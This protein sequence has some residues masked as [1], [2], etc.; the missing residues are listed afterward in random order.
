MIGLRKSWVRWIAVAAVTAACG[1][2]A[3]AADGGGP[4]GRK[5][6]RYAFPIAETAFDPAQVTDIYSNAVLSGIFEAPLEYTFLAAPVGMRPNT[7]A[8]MPEVSADFR[9]FTFRIRPGIYFA[10]D[11][12][13][14]GRKR[15]LVAEDYVYS[16]KRH[17]DPR[18]KSGKLSFFENEKI[19]G[20]SELRKKAIDAKKPFDYDT[21]AEGLRA[22]DRYTFQ[23]KLAEPS[24]RF[25]Y[26]Y[27]FGS[28][29][30]ALAR[31]VVEA[32]GDLIGEHPVG[33]GPFMLKEWKRSSRIV[34]VRNPNYRDVRYDESP[35][36]GSEHLAR[37]AGQLKGRR[38]PMVDEVHISII[39]ESQPR[40]LSFLNAEQ[41]LIEAV[42]SDFATVAFPNDR[43]APHLAKRGIT[44]ARYARADAAFSYF[45]MENPVVG[46]YE[47]HKVALRRAISLAV[48]VDR[49]IRLVRQ[50]QAV[51]AQGPM[52]PGTFG[53]DH[54]FKT[55]LSEFSP[56]RA[57]ALL[58][59]HGYVDRD[60]D[61]WREQPDGSPLVLRY[62]T[63]PDQLSRQYDELWQK[64]MRAIGLRIEF[65]VAKFPEHL[66]ASRAGR[67]MM[68]G[69]AW[70]GGEP[71]ADVFLSLAYGPNKGGVNH[72]R[73]DL[74]A[75]NALYEKQ[76]RLPDGPE[77][78]AVMKDAARLMVAYMPLKLQV[79][80]VATDL[81]HPWLVGYNRHTFNGLFWKYVDIDLAEQRRR[82]GGAAL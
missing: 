24:P 46:G 42:P 56:A 18:W 68:F 39:E 15:Q 9:T 74:P 2:A 78:L 61:G 52:P 53:H 43:L 80:R 38:L 4:Q 35:P 8:G 25:L 37:I 65:D 70:N 1:A 34:L 81:A 73:F 40:W 45:Q 44:M 50:G 82:G 47:P 72:S 31:E 14:K 27:V 54:Q 63:T 69:M 55:T 51:P 5:V 22:L 75:Y 10:D 3:A 79:H 71:D 28:Y 49:Q 20:L 77:R 41:D 76:R 48:D 13:F 66:K 29:A 19:L 30:G 6:L 64:N 11:A 57:Q 59:M 12:A 67:L 7:A 58:D 21:P 36:A 62:A 33:T 32:Y 16:I 23:V 17:Y 26:T 60:G